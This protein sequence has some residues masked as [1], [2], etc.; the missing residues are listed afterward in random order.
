MPFII[1]LCNVVETLNLPD[2]ELLRKMIESIQRMRDLF[3]EISRHLDLFK[4]LYE[5]ARNFVEAKTTESSAV[6]MGDFGTFFQ[7]ADMDVSFGPALVSAFT[8]PAPGDGTMQNESMQ[9]G[10][11]ILDVW[12]ETDFLQFDS[13]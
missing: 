2:L 10:G 4:P 6:A 13:F 3:P 1:I 8:H 5:V 7:E 11:S 9:F 12:S